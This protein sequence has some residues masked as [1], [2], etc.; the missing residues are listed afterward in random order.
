MYIQVQQDKGSSKIN[1]PLQWVKFYTPD[2]AHEDI[3]FCQK[4]SVFFLIFPQ[5]HSGMLWDFI[6]SIAIFIHLDTPLNP[7]MPNGL[8]FLNT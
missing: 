1:S 6:C 7:F 2:T 3:F 4:I 8:A 5:K